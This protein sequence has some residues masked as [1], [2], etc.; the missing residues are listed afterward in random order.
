M[1]HCMWFWCLGLLWNQK[2]HVNQLN[3]CFYIKCWTAF[4]SI[5]HFIQAN[6]FDFHF[7][8]ISELSDYFWVNTNSILN[9]CYNI[10]CYATKETDYI[11]QQLFSV[12]FKQK[13]TLTQIKCTNTDSTIQINSIKLNISNASYELPAICIQTKIN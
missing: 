3:G 10:Q 11:Y 1:Y 13:I 2:C 12:H 6:D 4:P 9:W 5:L 7:R 8:Q